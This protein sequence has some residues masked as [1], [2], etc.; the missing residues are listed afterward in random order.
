[1]A[2]RVQFYTTDLG[3]KVTKKPRCRFCG[4]IMRKT[5]IKAKKHGAVNKTVQQIPLW[6]CVECDVAIKDVM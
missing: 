3:L 2:K 5:F 6:Y 4:Q 1:M